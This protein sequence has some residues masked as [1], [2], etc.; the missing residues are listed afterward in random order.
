MDIGGGSGSA[1]VTFETLCAFHPAFALAILNGCP[2]R[3]SE[4]IVQAVFNSGATNNPIPASF[5]QMITSYSVFA[6]CDV[7]ID[8]TGAFNGSPFKAQSDA[9]LALGASGITVTILARTFGDQ[10]YSP[11][12]S[13]TPLQMIP[14]ILRKAAGIW[15]LENP[16]NVKCQFTLSST[17]QSASPPF[18][19]WLSFAFL[20]LSPAGANYLRLSAQEAR[21]QLQATLAALRGNGNAPGPLQQPPPS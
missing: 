9:F 18:T 5:D 15:H 2:V 8:P 6:G 4:R 11:I 3:P 14:S 7:S 16:D 20:C 12:P 10:D 1:L 19:V 13:D 17:P 21:A